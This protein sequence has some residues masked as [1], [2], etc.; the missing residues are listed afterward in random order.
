MVYRSWASSGRKARS[1]NSPASSSGNRAK[2]SSAGDTV[3]RLSGLGAQIHIGHQAENLDSP[4]VVVASTAVTQT[5]VE[6]TRAHEIGVPVIPR[7][8]MLAELMRLKQGIAVAGSHGKTTTT[9]L[10]A[11]FYMSRV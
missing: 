6:V 7:A 5:N 11:A 1:S 9:S 8:E 3:K 10:V 4:D 2:T